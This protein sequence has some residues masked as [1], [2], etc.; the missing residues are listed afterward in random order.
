MAA[1]YLWYSG[2][3]GLG[4]TPT[5]GTGGR[6]CWWGS[7]VRLCPSEVRLELELLVIRGWWEEAEDMVASL[8]RSLLAMGVATV[9]LLVSS[10]S[11]DMSE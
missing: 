3:P 5:L 8:G 2:V 9:R 11:S 10:P 1:R 4:P 7:E 6:G